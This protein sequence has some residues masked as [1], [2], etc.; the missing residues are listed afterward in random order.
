MGSASRPSRAETE[1]EPAPPSSDRGAA[2]LLSPSRGQIP[3]EVPD[4]ARPEGGVWVDGYW[5]WDGV[6][7]VRVPGR[8]EAAT[9]GYVR[10]WGD[11]GRDSGT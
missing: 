5:H 8:W 1:V 11:R 4:G 7:Y 2:E 9:P 6:Q 10:D 3:L